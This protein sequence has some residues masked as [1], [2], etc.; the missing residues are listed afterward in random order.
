[1]LL[2]RGPA[3]RGQNLG[4]RFVDPDLPLH[5]R[6]HHLHLHDRD[7]G[8]LRRHRGSAKLRHQPLAH[9]GLQQEKQIPSAAMVSS[10]L[11]TREK[12]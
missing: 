10:V 9:R 7:R 12:V 8:V 4:H 1:M 3:S 5:P 6:V 11:K 2:L